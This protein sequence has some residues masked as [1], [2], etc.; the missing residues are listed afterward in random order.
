MYSEILGLDINKIS[1]YTKEDIKEIY[2]KIALECHPD[3]L[4][5]IS[6]ENERTIRI[7]RFKKASIGYKNAI[8]DF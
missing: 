7:E 6:D 3:K 5:N 2:K 8:D 4:T 1:K